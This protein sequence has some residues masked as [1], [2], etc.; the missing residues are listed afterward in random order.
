MSATAAQRSSSGGISSGAIAVSVPRTWMAYVPASRSPSRL[1]RRLM[2]AVIVA[3]LPNVSQIS[4]TPSIARTSDCRKRTGPPSSRTTRSPTA[5]LPAERPRDRVSTVVGSTTIIV[6]LTT[7]TRIE[8]CALFWTSR[9]R[10][11]SSAAP[12]AA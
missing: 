12:A 11:S 9:D 5:S 6:T 4:T 8:T 3:R 10:P 7:T 2:I 1:E